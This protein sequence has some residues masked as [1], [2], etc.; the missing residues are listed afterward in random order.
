M[1]RVELKIRMNTDG[2]KPEI[3]YVKTVDV[4]IFITYVDEEGEIIETNEINCIKTDLKIDIK[5]G[6]IIFDRKR[7][8]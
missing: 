2:D 5:D 4:P 7:H 1:S 6:A 3:C 8:E